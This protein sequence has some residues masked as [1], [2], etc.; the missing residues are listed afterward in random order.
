MVVVMGD[1]PAWA[2]WWLR[3][4][5]NKQHEDRRRMP[6]LR[7]EAQGQ[8][9]SRESE[10]VAEATVVRTLEFEVEKCTRRCAATDR[11][12]RPGESFYSVLVPDGGKMRRVDYS[13]EAWQGPPENAIG[14]WRAQMPDPNARKVDWAPSDVIL[15]YFR[16]LIDRPDAQDTRYVLSLLMV[17]RRLLRLEETVVNEEGRE[18]LVL[19]CPKDEE[20]YR[21]AV[22]DPAADRLDAIQR[23]L[24]E[25]LFA[26]TS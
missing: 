8:G 20:E 4:D 16:N 19:F 21:V 22:A 1:R 9:R 12:L 15:Q 5:K 25:L 6:S 13:S 10:P 18:V 23:E 26:S 14:S 2:S 11:E 3:S 17:R 24:V 7:E